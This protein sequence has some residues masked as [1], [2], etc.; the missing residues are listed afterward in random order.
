M[1]RRKKHKRNRQVTPENSPPK[2]FAEYALPISEQAGAFLFL[3]EP[4]C[5][6]LWQEYQVAQRFSSSFISYAHSDKA[7]AARL[8]DALQAHGAHSWL[9]EK[10]I[11]PGQDIYAEIDFGIRE[12]D[13]ILL[14]CS[15]A[16]LNSWWV[17]NEVG[18]ALEKE[19]QLTKERGTKIAVIIPLNLDGYLFS[20]EWKSG[21]Q[22]QLRRRLAA[23]FT[24]WE[25]AS[26]EFE[27]ELEKLL[28][29]LKAD[30]LPKSKP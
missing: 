22:A 13:K 4:F 15:K 2:P 8:H 16:S 25:T 30:E 6:D 20:D 10:Q 3:V 14:C 1:N 26:S 19:Q 7:F 17:D 9:D 29:A 11:R 18:A 12:A 27:K 23:D 24:H 21:Y 5:N 28:W